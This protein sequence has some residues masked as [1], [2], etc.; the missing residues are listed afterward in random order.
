MDFIFIKKDKLSL[1]EIQMEYSSSFEVFEKRGQKESKVF[2]NDKFYLSIYDG[3]NSK[4]YFKEYSNGDFIVTLGTLFYGNRFGDDSLKPLMDDFKSGKR[5][6]YNELIGSYSVLIFINNKL[7]VFNDFIGLKRIYFSTDKSIFSSSF[8]AT[9]QSLKTKTPS[10]QEIYEYIIRGGMYGDKT[11]LKEINLISRSTAVCVSGNSLDEKLGFAYEKLSFY[12]NFDKMVNHVSNEYINIFKIITRVFGNN[13]TTALSGG[14]DSRLILALLR[15]NGIKPKL[16]VY[17][18]DDSPDVKIAKNI[19]KGEGFDLEHIDR[20]SFSKLKISEYEALVESNF[21]LF[22]GLNT[23]GIFDNGTDVKTRKIRSSEGIVQLNGGGGEVWRNFWQLN[24]FEK[25]SINFARH[26]WDIFDY[27]AYSDKFNRIKFFDNFAK[28]IEK[29]INH[30]IDT[31]R[32]SRKEM[33]MSYPLF[34]NRYWQSLGNSINL[35]FSNAIMPLMDTQFLYPSFDLPIQF[36]YNGVFEAA[37]IKKI[38]PKLAGYPSDRGFNFS[39]SVPFKIR[40]KSFVVRHIPLIIKP[41]LRYRFSNRSNGFMPYFLDE[42]YVS[43]VIDLNNLFISDYI[44]FRK[45]KNP[46]TLSRVFTLEYFF[47]HI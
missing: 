38:D 5:N 6:L 45:I 21:Y 44:D 14:Y 47:N 37:L 32:L 34:R 28:K 11:I 22:D 19:A 12:N 8:L 9:A 15:K 39:G 13:I 26:K 41:Y 29:S 16:Y 4:C 27:S 42:K 2:E 31:K 24:S 35:I 10:T 23:I 7:Y 17:G 40:F 1:K 30:L 20:D 18:S 36:K 46:E 25:S 3:L 33:E 43:Q